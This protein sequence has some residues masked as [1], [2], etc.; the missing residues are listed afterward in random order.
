MQRRLGAIE[1]RK[2]RTLS[3][4]PYYR[5]AL[6]FPMLDRLIAKSFI[7]CDKEGDWRVTAS[8]YAALARRKSRFRRMK[9]VARKALL[10]E[11]LA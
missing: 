11:F 9:T 8:G 1:A 3:V 10:K 4:N 2:L 7:T 6:G 5:M